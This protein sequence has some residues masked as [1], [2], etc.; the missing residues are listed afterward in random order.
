MVDWVRL[1]CTW[2]EA[3]LRLDAFNTGARTWAESALAS[4]ASSI[5]AVLPYGY[6]P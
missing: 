4:W 5:C 1:A 2:S 6:G 3:C